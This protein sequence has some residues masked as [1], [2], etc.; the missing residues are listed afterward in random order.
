MKQRKNAELLRIIKDRNLSKS[1]IMNRLNLIIDAESAMPDAERD[2]EL[3]NACID[4]QWYLMTGEHYKSNKG[5]ARKKLNRMLHTRS[6]SRMKRPLI[7]FAT[8]I[9]ITAAALVLPMVVQALLERSWIEGTT[10]EGGEVYQLNGEEV[11]PKQL[12]SA[13]ADSVDEDISIITSD[14]ALIAEL[15]SI[16]EIHPQYVPEGWFGYQYQYIRNNDIVFY[17]EEY[18]STESKESYYTYRCTIYPDSDAVIESIE[19]EEAGVMTVV[20]KYNVYWT[21]NLGDYVATW[22]E[23]LPSYILSAPFNEEE[24]SKIINSIGDG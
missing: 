3:I 10:I 18:K 21:Q 4:L 7:A 11:D 6:M 23:E 15:P 2:D 8:A 24:I 1:E 16:K 22:N 5:V 12:A 17:I 20:G 9:S 19:Q 14:Y 13:I